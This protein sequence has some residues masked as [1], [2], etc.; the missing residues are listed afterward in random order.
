MDG[1]IGRLMGESYNLGQN[2]RLHASMVYTARASS[3]H[4]VVLKAYSPHVSRRN[5]PSLRCDTRPGV[6]VVNQESGK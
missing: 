2:S 4:L 6:V 3:A 1:C 5:P